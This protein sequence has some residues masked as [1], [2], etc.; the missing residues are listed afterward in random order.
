MSAPASRRWHLGARHERLEG[1][2]RIGRWTLVPAAVAYAV[3]VIAQLPQPWPWFAWDSRAYYD[4]LQAADPYANAAVGGMGAYL[5]SPAFLQLL[6]PAGRLSWPTFLYVWTLLNGLIALALTYEFLLRRRWAIV[7]IATVAFFDIGAGNVN[8]LMA[9]AIVVGFRWPATWAFL[10]L[11]KVT[12]G[13]G[14]IWFGVR[15]EWLKLGIAL[16]ATAAVIAASVLF[17]AGAWSDWLKVLLSN[18]DAKN[19]SGALPIPALVRFPAAVGL[20]IWGALGNRRWVVPMA[21][22]LLLPVIWPNGLAMLVGCAALLH[23]SSATIPE[24]SMRRGTA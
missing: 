7:P 19:L 15:R 1:A 12:P 5:Y 14:V 6:A 10:P 4:A 8:L 3:L 11:T 21:C 22:C 16:G 17:D 2:W 13:I 20:L 18:A 23:A 24:S 9:A